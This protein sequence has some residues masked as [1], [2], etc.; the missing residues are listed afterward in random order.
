MGE[1]VAS[2]LEWLAEFGYLGISIGLMVEVI[3]S[4]IVLSWAGFLVAKK[5]IHFVG[6]VVAGTIGGTIAQIFLYWLGRYGGRP[7]LER[8]GKYLLIR[9][10]HFDL[11]E[12]WFKK[13]GNIVIFVARF[14]PVVRHAISIPAGLA[15]MSFFT[16]T[17]YTTLAIIPWSIFFVWIGY[18]LG[19]NWKTVDEHARPYVSPVISIAVIAIILYVGWHIWRYMK[20]R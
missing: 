9:R 5:E 10:K 11:S 17:L 7:V 20:S 6:A 18:T 14:I 2:V 19:D 15:Q 13:Y 4:E 12:Q 16:F 3:P 1:W 8:Y